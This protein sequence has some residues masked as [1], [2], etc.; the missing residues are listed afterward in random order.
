MISAILYA[1]V[2]LKQQ[3]IVAS[4]YLTM[5]SLPNHWLGGFVFQTLS[6][7]RNLAMINRVG[8]AKHKFEGYVPAASEWHWNDLERLLAWT[9]RRCIRLLRSYDSATQLLWHPGESSVRSGSLLSIASDSPCPNPVCI[10]LHQIN[11][12]PLATDMLQLRYSTL[13]LTTSQSTLYRSI[14]HEP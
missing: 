2:Y 9:C 10:S 11:A 1:D 4:Y 13:A 6:G 7:I 14:N 12:L 5:A 3:N 8:G